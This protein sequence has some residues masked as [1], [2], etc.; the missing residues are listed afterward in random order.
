[1]LNE[2]RVLVEDDSL[3]SDVAHEVAIPVVLTGQTMRRYVAVE[4]LGR[5]AVAAVEVNQFKTLARQQKEYR[6][7]AV[8]FGGNTTLMY[9]VKDG[10]SELSLALRTKQRDAVITAGARVV[11]RASSF[12]ACSIFRAAL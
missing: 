1:M 6:T 4:N 12:I 5:D 9:M 11:M 8:L 7:V 3:A 2:L 10:A